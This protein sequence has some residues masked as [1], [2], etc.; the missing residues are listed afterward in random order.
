FIKKEAV[1]RANLE[2]ARVMNHTKQ[3][4]KG[5]ERT[6]ERYGERIKK[7]EPRIEKAKQQLAEK[8][9]A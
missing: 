9:N 4:P 3:A 5:W 6:A 2:V 8:G 7:A 1:K